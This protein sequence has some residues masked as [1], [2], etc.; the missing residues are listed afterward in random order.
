MGYKLAGYEVIG[1]CEI[2]HAMNKVYVAN[3]HPKFNY[4]MDVREFGAIDNDKLPEELL[5]LD[6]LDGS[7]P[8]FVAGT[9]VRVRDGYKPIEEI[10]IGDEVLTH[11]GRFR[12][13]L[14]LMHH[15]ANNVCKV[16]IQG[17]VPIECTP[18]HPFLTRR[19]VRKGHEQSRTFGEPCWKPAGELSIV[20]TASTTK[21][22]DYV[23]IPVN[24]ESK[25]PEWNG[26]M[27]EHVIYGK[28]SKYDI[29]NSLELSSPDFWRF[30]G[31]Y[32]GDGWRR[33]DRKAVFICDGKDKKEELA[34]VIRKAGLHGVATEQ[35]TAWRFE[36]SSAELYEFLDAFGN[37]AGNKKIPEFVL[38]LPVDLLSA[39]MDGY[40]SA[41]GTRTPRDGKWRLSTVSPE[42]AFGMQAIVAKLW[43]QPS[44]M[45]T[46][47]NSGSVI[48]GREVNCKP[49]YDLAFFMEK[50]PQQHAI[51]EDGYLWV[52]FRKIEKAEP[53]RVYNLSV[54]EDESYTVY[55]ITVHNC[56][57]FSSAGE[58]EKG[59]N[60]EKQFREGQK[61]QRLDDLFFWFIDIAKKL[62]PK[63][64][65]AE[66]VK[67]LT[68]GNAKGYVNEIFKAFRAAGY[69]PQMFLMNGAS[70]GV[71]QRRERVFF[72]A[73][74]NDMNFPK[75]KLAF[76]EPPILFGDVRTENGVPL[77][78]G[79]TIKKLLDNRKPTD[80][81]LADINE[82]LSGKYKGFTNYIWSD[83]QVCGT[84][85][86]GG[87][88][89]RM[90]DGKGM[91]KQDFV[92]VQ[93]FPQDYDFID[94]NPQYVCGMSVPPVMMAQIAHQVEIQ[95]LKQG[96]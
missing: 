65:I 49:A 17:A 71:P 81:K 7:P 32:V 31:R 1:N 21:E 57:V 19:M 61:M 83:D 87:S 63:V 59:W 9:L 62:Q 79:S 45:T 54:E 89:F 94:Q 48:E 51:Y 41:D 44:T 64:V 43:K 23:A 6:I 18:N 69:Q 3:H 77:K 27:T 12:K 2:D 95:W 37:G 78:E 38:D 36:I 93:T 10:E 75:I 74:R 66:N 39:F 25:I 40:L 33:K 47:D 8:C 91:S 58:R 11:K 55:N 73:Q 34:E 56:S 60:T 76:H 50:H 68:A 96:G 52:P 88:Y 13:V 20:K 5:H 67:G 30:V 4:N 90:Y 15:D 46:K 85:A 14:A 28:S 16:K 24:T 92:N 82:R 29:K 26:V 80:R 70:M 72:I 53:R 86:S 84:I 42:L 22:Q 35:R